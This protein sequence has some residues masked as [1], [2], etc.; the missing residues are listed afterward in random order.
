MAA[1]SL[2]EQIRTRWANARATHNPVLDRSNR[3]LGIDRVQVHDDVNHL[4]SELDKTAVAVAKLDSLADEIA[5]YGGQD[6]ALA[7]DTYR[8][9]AKILRGEA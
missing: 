1:P 8:H 9:A 4:L 5:G 3:G 2:T 6:D 7:A